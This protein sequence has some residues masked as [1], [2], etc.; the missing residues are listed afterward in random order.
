MSIFEM[1]YTYHNAYQRL[2]AYFKAYKTHFLHI[3]SV[4]QAISCST[5]E[6]GC[7]F[8][9]GDLERLIF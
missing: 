3:L 1:N 8:L 6:G 7:C 5:L 2:N 4:L 9:P